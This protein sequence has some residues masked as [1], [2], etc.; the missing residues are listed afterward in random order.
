MFKTVKG[1]DANITMTQ[2]NVTTSGYVSP[3]VLEQ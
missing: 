1:E 3:E 2:A